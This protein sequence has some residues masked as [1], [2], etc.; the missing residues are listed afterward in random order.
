[1]AVLCIPRSTH[2]LTKHVG[3]AITVLTCIR[4]VP[5]DINVFPQSL[6]ANVGIIA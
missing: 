3:E 1:M 2:S 6:M 4:E 5:G